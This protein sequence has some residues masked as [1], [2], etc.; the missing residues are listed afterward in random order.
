M[1]TTTSHT[2]RHGAEHAAAVCHS[3]LQPAP[4]DLIRVGSRR[5]FLQTG[6]AGLAGLSLPDLLRC[7]ARGAAAGR[8]DRK[9]VILIWLSGGPSQ[10]DTWDPKPDAPSEVRGPFG[11]TATKVPGVR[12]SEYFPLQATIV[13]RLAII[14]SVDCQASTDHF[15][16]PMQAGNPLAQRHKTNPYIGTHPSMGSVAARFRGPNDPAMPA[17]VGMADPN[18]F[19]ADVLGAGPLGGAYEA[20]DA[21]QLAGRLTL[22]RGVTV[23]RAEDRAGLCR[24]FDRL[25]RDLDARDTMARMD[26]YRRQALGIVLSGKA[27]RAFRLDLEPDRVR[28]TY[29][30]HSFGEKMLLARRLVE[31]GVTFVTVS[32]IF[33]YFDNHGDD[34]VW[35][36]LMKGLKP[37]L[38]RLDQALCALVRDL[39]ARGLL[40][41]TL[42]LALGE[43]GRSPLF[44][45]RGTGGREHWP[46]CM[47]M[48]VAGGGL[49]HGQVVGSTDAKGGEVKDGRVTPSDLGATVYRHLGI[50]LASQWT[51]LQGRPQPVIT[52]G[53]RPIPELSE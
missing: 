15:P 10:L 18:L 28:D 53:G 23:A 19:F 50:D 40:D 44:S 38:P 1:M 21:A 17:F 37:L 49:T 39:E 11:S 3:P 26:Q 51:D 34:V 6:L 24:Q 32:P 42:V 41:D 35:G 22:P 12:I 5:W 31:A 27:R 4:S 43:F 47:S 52:E 14:R 13:D 29:G 7:R 36:G 33:G 25:R 46:N 20:A 8:A 9:A 2:G 16:A 30:R 48:L 45:Q